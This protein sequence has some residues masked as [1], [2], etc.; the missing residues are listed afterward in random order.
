MGLGWAGCS[1]GQV[2]GLGFQLLFPGFGGPACFGEE[3]GSDYTE[4][5]GARC[6][7]G[8]CRVSL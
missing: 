4:E 8:G 2:V 7:H 1:A 5:G 3:R 6:K